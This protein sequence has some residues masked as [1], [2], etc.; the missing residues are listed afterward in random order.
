MLRAG[1]SGLAAATALV[2]LAPA[3]AH[4]VLDVY[5]QVD[6]QRLSPAPLVFT[7]VPRSMRPIT[8]NLTGGPGRRRG[9]YNLRLQSDGGGGDEVIFLEGG[10]YRSLSRL[11]RANR[12]M[13]FITKRKRTRVRGKRG[14]II[15]NGSGPDQRVLAWSEGGRVYSLSTGTP[16]KVSV[17]QLRS[18]A[19]SLDRLVGAYAGSTADPESE[20]SAE[21][22]LTRRTVSGR[23]SWQGQCTSPGVTG[24]SPRVGGA[25]VTLLRRPANAFTVDIARNRRDGEEF[26]WTGTIQGTVARS[27]VGL[28]VRATGSSSEETCN[29]GAQAYSLTRVRKR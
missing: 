13:N 5:T 1:C 21:L 9:S 14:F 28:T 4:A 12:R 24:S 7:T 20:A 26:P 11:V 15:T 2:L 29:T 23:I 16:R 27:G 10:Q 3:P 18:T 22:V 25:E 6:Q 19:A 8:Q 17:R